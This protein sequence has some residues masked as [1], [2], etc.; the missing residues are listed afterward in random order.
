MRESCVTNNNNNNN[1]N[2][3][4]Q[5]GPL[6]L[7]QIASSKLG[8]VVSKFWTSSRRKPTRKGHTACVAYWRPQRAHHKISVLQ[9]V[10]ALNLNGFSETAPE[11]ENTHKLW[12]RNARSRHGPCSLK[13]VARMCYI[14]WAYS[15]NGTIPS[16]PAD[17]HTF[18]YLNG[19][20]GQHRHGRVFVHKNGSVIRMHRVRVYPISGPFRNRVS[21]PST[22]HIV[23]WTTYKVFLI[24]SSN[25]IRKF[26]Q[27]IQCPK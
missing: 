11:T 3:I 20:A 25:S 23:R 15:S 16:Q 9:N 22:V 6:S 21:K 10:T 14:R 19:N 13:T 5:V 4:C 17:E 2:N 27:E 12:T 8:T 24:N 7:R 18:F 1:N 26:C